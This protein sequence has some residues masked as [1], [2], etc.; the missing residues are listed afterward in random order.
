[1]ELPFL[2][3]AEAFDLPL[4]RRN[5]QLASSAKENA[6]EAVRVSRKWMRS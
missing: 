2:W 6:L 5:S 1:M 4:T 3:N